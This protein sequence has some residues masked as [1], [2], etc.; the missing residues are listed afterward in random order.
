MDA[1]E[2]LMIERGQSRTQ[3]IVERLQVLKASKEVIKTFQRRQGALHQ[4]AS[5]DFY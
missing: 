3:V 5:D 2:E 1:I 4:D